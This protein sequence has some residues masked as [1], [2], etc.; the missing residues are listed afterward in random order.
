VTESREGYLN[1][2]ALLR[3]HHT[4]N[5]AAEREVRRQLSDSE[6]DDVIAA[7][8]SLAGWLLTAYCR[9]SGTSAEAALD[10]LLATISE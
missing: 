7:L 4:G 2:A 3:A 1:A 6:R 10:L 8:T 5:R 9:S